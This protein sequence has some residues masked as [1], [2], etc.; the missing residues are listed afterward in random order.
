MAS[1]VP[2]TNKAGEITSHQVKWRDPGGAGW[3]IER[4]DDEDAAKV[5]K[6][7]VEESGNNWPLGWVKGKG[8]IDPATSDDLQYRFEP[9]ARRS[10]ENRTAGDYYKIQKIRALEMYLFPT[11]GNCDVRSAEH[12]SK[13]T[14][15]SWLNVMR[16]TTVFRGKSKKA[17]SCRR[18]RSV[19]CT[20]CSRRSW[21]KR[22]SPSRR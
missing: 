8:Y 10:I 5:F 17:R 21:R 19:V 4:F 2:R 15:S 7:A 6:A 1:V 11:F 22:S 12:F 13:D 14:V 9:Y 16:K 18:R 3:Q 20:G